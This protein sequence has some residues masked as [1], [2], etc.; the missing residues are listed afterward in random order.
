[1]E[2]K[3]VCLDRISEGFLVLYFADEE[4]AKLPPLQI[5]QKEYPSLKEGDYLW[6]S[7]KDGAVCA[8]EKDE[9]ETQKR[10]AE[11]EMLWKALLQKKRKNK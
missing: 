10:K 3:L 6:V 2:R 9:G 5:P 11:I 7:L 4:D 1:M 8:L